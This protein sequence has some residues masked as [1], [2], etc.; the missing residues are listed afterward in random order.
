M[1]AWPHDQLGPRVKSHGSNSHCPCCLWPFLTLSPLRPGQQRPGGL[2]PALCRRREG[3]QAWV[4][5][6][7]QPKDLSSLNATKRQADTSLDA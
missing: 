3:G 1:S 5:W 4:S 7:H 2:S 6:S